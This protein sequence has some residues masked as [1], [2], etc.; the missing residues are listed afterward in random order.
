MKVVGLCSFL[1]IGRKFPDNAN[2]HLPNKSL[3]TI[4]RLFILYLAK[5]KPL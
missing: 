3:K 5:Y 2:V 1:D 4:C